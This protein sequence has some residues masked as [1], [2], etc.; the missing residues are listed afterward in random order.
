MLL[1]DVT[2]V[3][4]A[5]PNIQSDLDSS[6]SQLQWVIDAYALSLA[7]LVLT[8][9]SLADLYGR[10]LL[11]ALGILVFTVGSLLCGISPTAT[12]LDLARG[13][14]GVGA[15]LMFATSLALLA[16]EFHGRERGTAFGI[17]GA[18]TGGAIAI[19][20][21]AGGIVTEALGWRWIFLLNVPIGIA[22]LVVTLTRV[23]ESR[24]PQHGGVDMPG[25]LTFSGGLFLLVYGLVRGN[26]AGWGS[27]EIVSALVVAT[28]LLI[29][30][31]VVEI[32]S[33]RPMLDLRLF[34]IPAFA[35]A[36]IAAFALAGSAF[37]IFLYLTLYMQNILGY[38][39]LET[40]I[41]FLPISLLSFVV[42]PISGKLSSQ[43]PVRVLIGGGLAVC[44]LAMALMHGVTP[45]SGWSELLPGFILLGVGIGLVNPP[46]A[47]TSVGVVPPQSTG[48]GAGANTTS[49]QV[50]LATG[51]ALLGAVFEHHL[52]SSLGT[53]GRGVATGVVPPSVRETAEAAFVSG[54][55]QLFVIAAVIG[56]IGAILSFVLIRTPGAPGGVS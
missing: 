37:A 9:G 15:A 16:Q 7:A 17:W 45:T 49:R 28:L 43:A 40:G 10:R 33:P 55:D 11:F 38:S 31:V 21:L 3:N 25:V 5:L 48:M 30:F 53:A 4:V 52:T 27:V 24:D 14:Q 34:E 29:A 8:A 2:I 20:P 22:A 36:Q 50:G 47:S 19:G 13:L 56:V 44:A 12:F 18:T 1:L 23:G 46:L 32:R 41:R 6:F 42:A 54:L 51:V 39:P 35:G 26:T